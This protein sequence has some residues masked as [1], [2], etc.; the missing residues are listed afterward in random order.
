MR[1]LSYEIIQ[2]S[3]DFLSDSAILVQSWKRHAYIRSH[4]WY[5]D[6]LELDVSALRLNSLV[7]EWSKLLT[8]DE[9]QNYSPGPMRLVPAPKSH[10]WTLE[11]G[12]KPSIMRIAN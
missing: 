12:W 7:N 11:D 2:P 9:I 5:A 6:S 8:A 10:P 1:A 3:A 4:N